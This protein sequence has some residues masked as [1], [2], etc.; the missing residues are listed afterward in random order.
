MRSLHAD[1]LKPL[2]HTW[3]AGVQ[4]WYRH[5]VARPDQLVPS[6]VALATDDYKRQ[7]GRVGVKTVSPLR[8][9]IHAS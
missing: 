3:E 1:P 5:I 6:I 8:L 9:L 7:L 2:A 4:T